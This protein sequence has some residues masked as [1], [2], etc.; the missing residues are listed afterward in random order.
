MSHSNQPDRQSLLAQLAAITTMQRGTL[1]EEYREVPA[2]EGKGTIRLGPYFKHQC[3]Q[4]G[5]NLSR[6]V[7]V[8]EVALLR[9]DLS[10]AQRFDA[11]TEQLA[12][13]NIASTRQLRATQRQALQEDQ[14][15]SKKNSSKHAQKRSSPKPSA[16][17]PR[18][19]KK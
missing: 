2:P 3:W 14:I 19:R 11:L 6:R 17:S 10:N 9:E 7:S 1:A 8:H 15:E 13:A 4:D 12:Q 18:R 5:R 16:S